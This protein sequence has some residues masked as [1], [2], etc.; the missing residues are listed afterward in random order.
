MARNLEE[1]GG[2]AGMCTPDGE[3]IDIPWN[4]KDVSAQTGGEPLVE[5]A[6]RKQAQ[7]NKK[8]HGGS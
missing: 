6:R 7:M 2:A 4:M 5:Q 1:A 8:S 3:I